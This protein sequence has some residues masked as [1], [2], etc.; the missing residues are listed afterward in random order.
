M[1]TEHAL[2]LSTEAFCST[3]SSTKLSCVGA[4]SRPHMPIKSLLVWKPRFTD[5][6]VDLVVAMFTQ[7]PGADS[8]RAF[9]RGFL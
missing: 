5:F 6:T 8:G 1:H 4:G 7:A 9:M 3:L 2:S